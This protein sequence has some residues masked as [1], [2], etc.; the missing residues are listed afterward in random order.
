MTEKSKWEALWRRVCLST[1]ITNQI[2]KYRVR[3]YVNHLQVVKV[4]KSRKLAKAFVTFRPDNI[5]PKYLHD[6]VIT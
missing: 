6:L 5:E 4:E 3:M 2:S 1:H